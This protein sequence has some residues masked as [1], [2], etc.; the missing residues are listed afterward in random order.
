M[1][2]T[3]DSLRDDFCSFVNKEIKNKPLSWRTHKLK[4]VDIT[5]V[6]WY[7]VKK[8]F[9]VEIDGHKYD[10]KFGLNKEGEI[11]YSITFLGSPSLGSYETIERGFKEGVWYEILNE[12]LSDN[13]KEDIKKA[14]EERE[15]RE[16]IAFLMDRFNLSIEDLESFIG[17][18]TP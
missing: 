16:H 18:N 2:N 4:E 11:G 3:E 12:E 6:V 9:A 8:T 5:Y 15:R 13:E 1:I 10:I 7:L 17:E 14:I